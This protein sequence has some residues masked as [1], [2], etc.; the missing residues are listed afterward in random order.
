MREAVGDKGEETA[1]FEEPEGLQ[2][3]TLV[4]VESPLST[5]RARGEV[6]AATGKAAT[7]AG[8]TSFLEG[9]GGIT[10]C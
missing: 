1:A 7:A 8:T 9:R 6:G 2:E 5:D 4:M 3:D 10:D